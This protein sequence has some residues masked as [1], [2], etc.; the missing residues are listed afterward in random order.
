MSTSQRY[1]IIAD[2]GSFQPL[3]RTTFHRIIL[4]KA[5]APSPAFFGKRVQFA[6]IV[7]KLD[8]RRPVAVQRANFGYLTF[9]ANGEFDSSE[10]DDIGRSVIESWPAP[11]VA[12]NGTLV[13]A[14]HVFADRRIAHE[15][16][17]QPSAELRAELFAAATRRR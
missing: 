7:V 16:N 12:D 10:W 13:D 14:R 2:D 5:S 1:Y 9:D 15:H 4:Q 3:S 11:S 6:E 8:G 17:W